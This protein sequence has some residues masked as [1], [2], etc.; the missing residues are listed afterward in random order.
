MYYTQI[1][2]PRFLQLLGLSDSEAESELSELVCEKAIYARINRPQ[3]IINFCKKKTT[4]DVLNG[5]SENINEIVKTLEHT[6]HL[7]EK[8]EVH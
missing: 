4:N 1:R 3:G 2:Y 8:E 6:Y 7:I 5:W